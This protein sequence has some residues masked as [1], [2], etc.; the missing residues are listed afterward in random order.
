MRY[1][2]PNAYIL[3][4]TTYKI[5][6]AGFEPAI[7]ASK[8]LQNPM[9]IKTGYFPRRANINVVKKT[10]FCASVEYQ[11]SGIELA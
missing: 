2:I 9:D 8:R 4:K 11:I 7:P 5:H 3:D 1:G 10:T 6:P